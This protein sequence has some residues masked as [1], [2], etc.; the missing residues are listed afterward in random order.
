MTLSLEVCI[1]LLLIEVTLFGFE[2]LSSE[3]LFRGDGKFGH[4]FLFVIKFIFKFV[5]WSTHS[6]CYLVERVLDG[7]GKLRL[8]WGW[9][10]RYEITMPPLL[11]VIFIILLLLNLASFIIIEIN[12]VLEVIFVF[13]TE[14]LERES[15]AQSNSQVRF[16]VDSHQE[17]SQWKEFLIIF[18]LFK[19]SYWNTIAQL[20]SKS[21]DS[22]VDKNN[23][24]DLNVLNDAQIFDVYVILCLYAAVTIKSMLK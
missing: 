24:F 13:A 5:C 14:I 4:V 17:P 6:E 11:L 15:I 2:R 1:V 3:V 23:I 8:G 9:A 10:D 21:I 16:I 20:L 19:G 12:K 7:L 18:I 22:V